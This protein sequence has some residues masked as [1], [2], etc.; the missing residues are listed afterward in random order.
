MLALGGQGMRVGLMA[1]MARQLEQELFMPLAP[2]SAARWLGF[3]FGGPAIASAL[4]QV[5]AGFTLHRWSMRSMM[6]ASCLFSILGG[7]LALLANPAEQGET[8][9]WFFVL[10]CTLLGA[11]GGFLETVNNNL[12][13]ALFPADS[14]RKMN[15]LHAWWPGGMF[16]G[17]LAGAGLAAWHWSWRAQFAFALWPI[18]AMIALWPR[19]RFPAITAVPGTHSRSMLSEVMRPACLW[20]LLCMVFTSATE[21]LPPPWLPLTLSR[22][23]GVTGSVYLLFA[24]GLM[25]ALRQVLAAVAGRVA[26]LALVSISAVFAT[27]GMALFALARQPGSGAAAVLLWVLGTS[28]LWPAMLV[29]MSHRHPR[30]GALG[31]G[32]MGMVGTLSDFV[33]QP[34]FGH[35]YDRAKISLAGGALAFE[36][37]RGAALESVLAGA[38]RQTFLWA[39]VLPCLLLPLFGVLAWMKASPQADSKTKTHSR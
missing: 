10:G 1:V 39:T 34:L 37:L 8:A 5:L 22:N 33:A 14:A 21:L 17:A 30:A 19:V 7:A 15:A 38:S 24:F 32:L 25:F 26:P 9:L 28:A 23:T 4:A 16:L 12:V 13:P 2:L 18:A 3:A 31:I 29:L 11:G 35:L 36:A 20:L 27:A 6:A